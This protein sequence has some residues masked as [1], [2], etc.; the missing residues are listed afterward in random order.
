ML[1]NNLLA[2]ASDDPHTPNLH[3]KKGRMQSVAT[4]H[5]EMK[6]NYYIAYHVFTIKPGHKSLDR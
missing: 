4:G 5:I 2:S 1:D 3:E 6:I